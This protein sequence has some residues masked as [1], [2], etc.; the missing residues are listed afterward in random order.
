MTYIEEIEIIRNMQKIN[1]EKGW[2]VKV[3]RYSLLL[4]YF[5]VLLIII[6]IVQ[7]NNWVLDS[8]SNS[9]IER[10]NSLVFMNIW[11]KRDEMIIN[12]IN[13]NIRDY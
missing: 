8:I 5:S 13:F 10:C 11:A 2:T 12:I 1:K 3:K 7:I 9:R 4:N 6:L